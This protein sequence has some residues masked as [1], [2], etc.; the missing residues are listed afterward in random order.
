MEPYRKTYKP[1]AWWLLSLAAGLLALALPG[2]QYLPDQVTRLTV[3]ALL[4]WLPGLFVLIEW[5]GYPI[6]STESLPLSRL[7]RRERRGG[8]LAPEP[9]GGYLLGP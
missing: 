4:L 2:W 9:I 8:A 7:R 5:G 6:G 3:L 1:F